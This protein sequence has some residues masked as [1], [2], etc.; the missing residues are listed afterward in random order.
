MRLPDPQCSQVVLIGTGKY[1][2]GK[3]PDLPAVSRTVR[4]L[5]VALTDP[6]YGVVPGDHCRVLMDEGDIRLI[7]RRLRLA[8]KAAEDL[9]LVYYVGH[10]LVGGRRHE[11]YLGLPD[12]EWI[13]PE[14]NSLEYDKLRSA[15]LASPAGTKVIVLDCCFSGRVVGDTMADPAS[16]VI[17]QAEVE[18]TYVLAAAPRD[19]VALVLPGEDHTAFSGRLLKILHEGIPGGPELLSIDDIYQQLRAR[20]KAEGLPRPQKRG[21]NSAGSLALVRNRVYPATAVPLPLRR[22]AATAR[23]RDRAEWENATR[24]LHVLT[25]KERDTLRVSDNVPASQPA[26]PHAREGQNGSPVR[27]ARMLIRRPRIT[28]AIATALA[29][30]IVAIPL[31]RLTSAGDHSGDHP[32]TDPPTATRSALANSST[33]NHLVADS[34]SG[35]PKATYITSLTNPKYF[36]STIS[37]SPDGNSIA[38]GSSDPNNSGKGTVYLWN[39]TTR[40]PISVPDPENGSVFAVAY[41]PDGKTLAASDADSTIWFM[42]TKTR[43]YTSLTSP[44]NVAPGPLAYAP[45]GKTLAYG[46]ANSSTAIYLWDTTTH[47]SVKLSGPPRSDGIGSDDK[48][49]SIAYS[50]DGKML[51]ATYSNG[52]IWLWNTETLKYTPLPTPGDHDFESLAYAPDGKALAAGELQATYVWNTE[53]RHGGPLW[54]MSDIIEA[55]SVAYAP[56]GRILAVGYSNSVTWLWDTVSGKV[57]AKLNPPPGSEGLTSIAFNPAGTILAVGDESGSIYLWHISYAVGITQP[58]ASRF[59]TTQASSAQP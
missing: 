42:N 7:G 12:S 27:S 4:D 16:E 43:K 52:A 9:L 40:R 11:L 32:S 54:G 2:D 41:A 28:A 44:G 59:P 29:V 55:S 17:G 8:A 10:G 19:K 50:P 22:Y 15:V 49:D 6:V 48:V 31:Y 38:A 23:Q 20:M 37:F 5:A 47:K 58:G 21:T 46:D 18:G 26:R 3:L 24:P 35:S 13:E 14:F 57:D 33:A 30:S 36:P 56:G 25:S 39:T 1:A 34:A 45:D 53:T 51:A